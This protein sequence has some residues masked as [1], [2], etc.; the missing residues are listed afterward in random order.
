LTRPAVESFTAP[1]DRTPPLLAFARA[2][3]RFLS[4][5]S[6][7]TVIRVLAAEP[8]RFSA[9]A[10]AFEARGRGAF[11]TALLGVLHRLGD[12]GRISAP[13]PGV[14]AGQLM[15]MIEHAALVEPL[16][17]CDAA[18]PTRVLDQVCEEAIATFVARYGRHASAEAA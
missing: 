11:E 13:N 5:S 15:G 9:L 1:G 16:L 3:G 18:E 10:A 14:A 6:V 4:D 17:G 7:R 12:E 2:Y 8:R